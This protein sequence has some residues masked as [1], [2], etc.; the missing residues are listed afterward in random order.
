MKKLEQAMT[1]T[2]PTRQDIPN[3]HLYM[4]QLLEFYENTLGALKR[5]GEASVFTKTMINNYVKSGLVGPPTKKKYNSTAIEDLIII[6]HLKKSFSIQDISIIL[7]AIKT[8]GHYYDHFIN[9]YNN[10]RDGLQDT[11]AELSSDMD[12]LRL[13][14]QLIVEISFKKQLADILIDQIKDNKPFFT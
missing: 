7:D 11:T 4:D 6:Y 8:N 10:I 5:E 9:D 1:F 14:Q 2:N 13:L 3:I 12:C